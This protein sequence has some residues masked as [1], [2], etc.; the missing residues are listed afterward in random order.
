MLSKDDYDEFEFVFYKRRMDNTWGW[1]LR[2][3]DFHINNG[4]ARWKYPERAWPKF[5]AEVEKWFLNN[6][7]GV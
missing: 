5:V 4:S 3:T 2:G 6:R 7:V 1:Y